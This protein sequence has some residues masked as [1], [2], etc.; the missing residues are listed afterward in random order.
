MRDPMFRV[1]RHAAAA[2]LA[3]LACGAAPAQ[4]PRTTEPAVQPVV[5]AL[6][7]FNVPRI[8]SVTVS[9]A[10]THAAF[11]WRGNEG[12][13]V[14][15]VIDLAEPSKVRVV[16]GNRHLD[17]RN[18]HWVND[19]RLVF[20]AVPPELVIY[21]GEAGTFAIDHDGQRQQLLASWTN[22]IR[23]DL[24]TRVPTRV[25]PYGWGFFRALPGQGDEALFFQVENTAVGPGGVR[26]VARLDT[27]SGL[28]RRVS[29]G[30]PD[31]AFGQVAD[32][33]GELRIAVT[34]QGGR[35]RVHHRAS[36]SQEWKVVQDLPLFDSHRMH[37]LYIEADGKW[38]VR[39][40]RGRDTD[41]LFVYD[42]TT[43]RF[44]PE[45]L[46]AAE[47]FDMGSALEADDAKQMVVGVHIETSQPQ[48]VWLDERL[49]RLQ[50]A[51]DA[52]LPPGRMNQL[53][54][55]NCLTAQRFVVRSRS[56][57]M[58]G[59]YFVF[60]AVAKRLLPIADSRPGLTEASQGRRT[61]HRVAARDGLSLPVVVT[62]PPGVDAR[63]PRPLVVLVHGGPNMRG[64][65]R[66]WEAEPQFLAAR[67]H[68]VLEV[69]FRGST[70]FGERHLRAGFK[71]WGQA[72][73]D[74]LADA[75]AWAVREGLA[76]PGRACIVGGSYGGYAALMGP[77][78]HPE[79]Y[80][81]A[82][83]F[84]GVTD[85]TRVF[86]RFWTDIN[87]QARRYTLTETLGDPV[88]DKVMLERFSPLGRVADIRVP[89]LVTW[90]DRDTRVDPAHSR[91]FVAAA[92]A[93]G[94]PV[95]SHEYK[96]EGHGLLLVENQVDHAERLAR[97]L[98]THLR[99]AAR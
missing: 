8:T 62:H 52:A 4:A 55:G 49:A 72:M 84:N 71:Q 30:M 75:V 54:C 39:S 96:D 27:A 2:L 34:E 78:R 68:R 42:P 76:E 89:V 74:D 1:A 28:L 10:N 60:D 95:E 93:A 40:R 48:T 86:S 83:S 14:L 73:Q 61:F 11:L 36:G 26:A 94:V 77:V 9:P 33:R 24:G 87:E 45:P 65:S 17:I 43:D 59:E 81:C 90:G 70:G 88:A 82:A 58:P 16:A 56:D 53:L 46:V 13:L 99:P 51:V 5:Q 91:R 21:E 41:A 67:G 29:T 63:T 97:F 38:V 15:A 50:Q 32:G 20:D 98:D 37:P 79:L 57:R 69:E 23:Q 6:P 22:Q 66:A 25:L 19:R 64:S 44:D 35:A 85:T 7:Y 92:R 80:R 12:R 31:N 47:G 18:I 3:A